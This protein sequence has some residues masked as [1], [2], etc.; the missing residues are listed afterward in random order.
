M[1]VM[2]SEN[3]VVQNSDEIPPI[4]VI[5]KRLGQLF[6]LL[7]C[8]ITCPVSDF[9]RTGYFEPLPF[10]NGLNKQRGLDQGIMCPCVKPCDASSQN[11]DSQCTLFEVAAVYVGNLQFP[12]RGWFD[13]MGKSDNLIV[14]KI[15]ACNRIA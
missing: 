10:L 5:L 3:P 7:R 6:H 15:E 12:A 4:L 13:R 9:F 11:L 1:L 2:R 8:N 14:V